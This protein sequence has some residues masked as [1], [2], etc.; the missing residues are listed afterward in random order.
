MNIEWIIPC[1]YLEVHDNLA[2]IIGGGID[3]LWFPGLPAQAQ[4]LLAVRLLATP[5][6]VSSAEPHAVYSRIRHPGGETL[7]E[8]SGE[9]VIGGEPVRP[10]WL[11][12]MTV[13]MAVQF[14][15][16]EEGPYAIE[17]GVDDAESTVP[18]H[19]VLGEP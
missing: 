12:G 14:E 1:R 19:I 13:P 7:H 9:V 3:T 5:E 18:I 8:A 10:D 4:V 17:V 6:E 2:T 11:I 16:T 15:A